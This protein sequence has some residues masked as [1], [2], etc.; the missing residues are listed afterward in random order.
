MRTSVRRFSE[1][2][3]S[4]ETVILQ[5]AAAYKK[6]HDGKTASFASDRKGPIVS[7]KIHQSI[8]G[9]KRFYKTVD[10]VPVPSSNPVEVGLFLFLLRVEYFAL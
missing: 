3:N 7:E 5:K 9:R 2:L 6:A 1:L 4:S 10:V 8:A